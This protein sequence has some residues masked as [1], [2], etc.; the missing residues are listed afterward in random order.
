MTLSLSSSSTAFSTWWTRLRSGICNACSRKLANKAGKAVTACW[1]FFIWSHYSSSLYD[2][3]KNGSCSIDCEEHR[4]WTRQAPETLRQ[5]PCRETR[6]HGLHC[7]WQSWAH[8]FRNLSLWDIEEKPSERFW[9]TLNCASFLS[10]YEYGATELFQ[11]PKLLIRSTS[12]H[13]VV[14]RWTTGLTRIFDF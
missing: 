11:S 3:W 4:P 12:F 9:R 7:F 8:R 6:W 14:K 5:K 10:K 13:L 1:R 2:S